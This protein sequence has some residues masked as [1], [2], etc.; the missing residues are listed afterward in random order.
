MLCRGGGSGGSS[1]NQVGFPEWH[2][3]VLDGWEV[4]SG[5]VTVRCLTFADFLAR[6]SLFSQLRLF[7]GKVWICGFAQFVCFVLL[8]DA[9][10]KQLYSC[11]CAS[12]E[13]LTSFECCRFTSRNSAAGAETQKVGPEAGYLLRVA[14]NV[15]FSVYVHFLPTTHGCRATKHGCGQASDN[16][17]DG[18]NR[19]RIPAT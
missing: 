5:L 15:E 2:V 7:S 3:A 6:S 18:A 8:N 14:H 16:C 10:P 17:R 12:S 9:S 19:S 4:L 1:W 13:R 11:E